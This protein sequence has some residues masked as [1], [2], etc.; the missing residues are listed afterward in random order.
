MNMGKGLYITLLSALLLVSCAQQDEDNAPGSGFLLTLSDELAVS[1]KSAPA[2]LT[3]PVAE[4]FNLRIQ[5]AN[6][7]EAYN[8]RFTSQL[9]TASPGTYTLT[10][11]YGDNLPL[12]LDAPY[13]EGTA[14]ATVNTGETTSVD[15]PCRVANSLLS[16]VYKDKT[17][18]DEYLSDY[19]VQVKQGDY[20]V[21][22]QA[23]SDASAYF[24]PGTLPA[25][26]FYATLKG[27]L[28]KQVTTDIVIPADKLSAVAAGDH[29]KLTLAYEAITESGAILIV[30]KVEVVTETV[31]ETIPQSWLPTPKVTSTGFDENNT[32]TYYE[33]ETP[34]ASLDFTTAVG[35]QE[36]KFTI[37]FSDA[38]Y[39]SLNGEYTLSQLTDEQRQALTN[40][41]IVLPELNNPEA[42]SFDFS[43]LIAR[44]S[45]GD[46]DTVKSVDN[47][48][49]LTQVTANGKDLVDPQAYT[50]SIKRA[51]VFT[52]D[53]Q[54][55]NIW[56]K[57]F[58]ADVVSVS[59]GDADAVR[60]GVVYQ[61]S[62]TEGDYKVWQDCNDTAN[63]RHDFKVINPNYN[64]DGSTPDV[65]VRA[66][67]RGF[68]S[69]NV[70]YVPLEE[71]KQLPNS[72]MEAWNIT[73]ESVDGTLSGDKTY[74]NF[75][76]YAANETDVWWAT[77][78]QIGQNGTIAL[79]I[80]WKGCFASSTSYTTDA[81]SGS[82]AAL[83]FTNG[84]G[85][86]YASTKLILYTDGS[87]AGSLFIGSFNYNSSE[88]DGTPV[89]GHQYSSRP[90]AFSFWYKYKAISADQFSVWVAIK[91][92]DEI[93][94]ENTYQPETYAASTSDSA[95]KKVT[96]PLTYS[97]DKLMK[98][99][100]ICV[101]FLSTTKTS[102]SSS[103][104]DKGTYITYPE[105]GEWSV[106]L[107][108]QL[109]ID[110]LNLEFNK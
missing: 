78:N 36:V 13:Y 99:T 21:R 75:H 3:K 46:D 44:L 64:A 100:T 65:W 83:I 31:A 16:V 59:A 89:H 34:E 24:H 61:Y 70:K 14:T 97:E 92:G 23:D 4:N 43:Q 110:D 28:Q 57:E 73:T 74:Y 108:S 5:K 54:D 93:I 39:Q 98:A 47:V 1:T 77:N 67:F 88:Y 7:V 45:A 72:D 66:K 103:D 90:T 87:Y 35:L 62:T 11:S 91:N 37:N 63:R 81:N 109:Y 25:L 60:A 8:G 33:T 38:T 50:L 2:E 58:T 26:Q 95:Y 104:F 40:A 48:F 41:G 106:H 80:W 105:V 9:I 107:G 52:V 20:S 53:V 79:G 27:D 49:Q 18:F 101:Q 96:I 42:A 84:H 68:V 19:G 76:P 69:Q 17:P 56:A 29:V 6:G 82:K 71:Q 55:V 32:L 12:A 102:F 51:P 94:T 10:A 15:I 30:E 86:H 22:L 85:H